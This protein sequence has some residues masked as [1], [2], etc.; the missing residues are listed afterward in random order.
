MKKFIF[1]L[2]A[3]AVVGATMS[4]EKEQ[5][6]ET[7]NPNEIVDP[8]TEP[9][10]SGVK[11]ELVGCWTTTFNI[12]GYG[13][14][15]EYTLYLW[16]DGKGYNVIDDY[17][18]DGSY[19]GLSRSYLEW[20]TEGDTLYFVYPHDEPMACIYHVDNSTLTLYRELS[21]IPELTFSRQKEADHRFMGDW[22]VTKKCGDNYVD[23]HIKFVTPK[24]CCT[25]YFEYT[26][27]NLPPVDQSVGFVWYKYEFDD[28]T[29]TLTCVKS[30]STIKKEY[31]IDG[32]KLYLNGECYSNFK[33]ENGFE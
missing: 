11:S 21:D 17:C 10:K 5:L 24:D 30:G 20:Y 25:Y 3:L 1:L 8:S 14:N 16:D 32:T 29:I 12:D 26:D 23:E 22:S 4:C 6:P 13:V 33:K 9:D 7:A 2:F 28:N 31:K 18:L 19:A 15:Y 27:P